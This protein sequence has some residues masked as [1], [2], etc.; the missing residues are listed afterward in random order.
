MYKTR[1]ILWLGCLLTAVGAQA[2]SFTLPDYEKVELRNGL[3]LYLL[4]Q[5]EV[6]L[7]SLAMVLPAGTVYENQQPGLAA[8]TA[9]A[10]LFGAG[11][12]SKQDIVEALDFVGARLSTYA[13][14]ETARIEAS[15]A[16]KDTELVLGILRDMLVAPTFVPAEW[17]KLQSRLL[18][19]Y[20]QSKESPRSV[21]GSYFDA[22][23]YG[24]HPYGRAGS[25]TKAGLQ[26]IS[27]NDIRT[28]YQQHYRPQGSALAIVGDFDAKAMR[29]RLQNLL[30][31]WKGTGKAPG[32]KLA[33]A[34]PPTTARVLLV[35]KPDARETTFYIGGP[36]IS[37]ANPDYVALQVINTILGARFTS[38]LN[39]ELRV[40]SGL[41]Y[42]ARSAFQTLRDGGTFTISTF[43]KNESTEAAVDLALKTYSRLHG[44]GIDAQTLAS[45]KNYVKGQ[46]PPRYETSSDLAELL[47][48]MYWYGFDE[49]FINTFEQR[50]DALDVE[51]ANALSRQYFP[52]DN[53]QFVLIGRAEELRE[54]AKKWGT[55]S[56]KAITDDGF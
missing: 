1:I 36:G 56:E 46:L 35:D 20:D 24:S 54:L 23:I 14:K 47:V 50:V 12:R 5:R 44:Q 17:E 26:A 8:V 28:F 51:R 3:T 32:L 11:Q 38:W 55:V 4:E 42:G 25:G 7:I 49:Q 10:L 15:F 31:D 19:Q 27:I 6:P 40:N 29:Q 43:T 22:F 41:T 53:L 33:R 16:K 48:D 45:A 13:T 21:I 52:R 30:K 9:D 39:D 2:Q 37:R 18:A 34:T